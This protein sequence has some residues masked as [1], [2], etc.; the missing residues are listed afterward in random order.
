MS[1]AYGYDECVQVSSDEEKLFSSVVRYVQDGYG[2]VHT[3]TLSSHIPFDNGASLSDLE[4]PHDM[5]KLMS[6]YLKSMNYVDSILPIIFSQTME[7][8]ALEHSTVVITGDHT[9][10]HE[11]RAKAF[12]DYARG[13]GYDNRIYP[14]YCPLLIISPDIEENTKVEDICYQM[15]IYPTVRSIVGDAAMPWKGFGVDL[16][17]PN[18]L[19]SR[20]IEPET[21]STLSDKMIK[22]D[23]F[24]NFENE[25]D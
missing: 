7:G 16:L 2:L 18:A 1:C 13:K 3:F 15:D 24:K 11:D 21:A 17:S 22:S 23:Y 4:L 20:E 5:P 9:I 12:E 10:F 14:N 8:G 6:D 25:I 19:L